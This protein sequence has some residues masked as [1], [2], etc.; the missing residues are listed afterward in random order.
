MVNVVTKGSSVALDRFTFPLG[1]LPASRRRLLITFDN[2]DRVVFS[3]GCV[4][5][6]L[7][8]F[9]LFSVSL[10]FVTSG[11]RDISGD[12]GV[13]VV[14]SS[15][16]VLETSKIGDVFFVLKISSNLVAVL[17]E[18]VFLLSNSLR[19]SRSI[20]ISLTISCLLNVRSKHFRAFSISS[21]LSF[22]CT[23]PNASSESVKQ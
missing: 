5:V 19:F 9:L 18:V 23:N 15:F 12:K 21:S 6:L 4:A 7:R 20:S 13:V 11:D 14:V 22:T 17:L 8:T 3:S 2:G 10:S 1:G 16:F